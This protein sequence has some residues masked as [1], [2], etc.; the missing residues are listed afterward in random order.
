SEHPIARAIASAAA[1]DAALPAVESFQN[2]EGRGVSGVVEGHALLVGRVSLL[3]DWSVHPSDELLAAKADAESAGQTAV[4]VAWD[5]AAR[6]MVVVADEVKPTS[7][8]AVTSLKA[9]GITPILL[10]GDNEAAARHIAALVGI[11]QGH[12]EVL[13]VDKVAVVAQLQA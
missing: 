2:I 7:A 5:G 8:E 6:G 1:A 3:E 12:A 10:T 11:E 13:P 9:L 4:L